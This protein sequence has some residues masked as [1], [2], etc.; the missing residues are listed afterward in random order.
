MVAELAVLL[1]ERLDGEPETFASNER[2]RLHGMNG[3]Q[4]HRIL[5]RMT[6]YVETQSGRASR[7]EEYIKRGGKNGTKS[8]T[9]GRIMQTGT[10]TSSGTPRT[11]RIPQPH[12][13]LA[14]AAKE[15]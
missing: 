7:Y 1:K 14:L 15:L 6:D 2:F 8:N 3:R 4:I 12:W 9:S 11:S 10:K 5:A 13:R